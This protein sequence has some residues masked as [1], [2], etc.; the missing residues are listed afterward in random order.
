MDPRPGSVGAAAKLYIP[1]QRPSDAGPYPC[2]KTTS[3][4]PASCVCLGRSGTFALCGLASSCGGQHVDGELE[5]KP[6]ACSSGKLAV[7]EADHAQVVLSSQHSTPH[8]SRKLWQVVS[9]GRWYLTSA[10]SGRSWTAAGKYV[11]HAI[12]ATARAQERVELDESS[13]G[14]V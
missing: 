8:V 14:V 1:V 9:Q 11:K 6:G 7:T 13:N 10:P 3:R 12:L 2:S 5:S 4:P